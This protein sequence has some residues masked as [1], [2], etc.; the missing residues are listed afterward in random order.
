MSYQGL[1]PRFMSVRIKSFARGALEFIEQSPNNFVDILAGYTKLFSMRGIPWFLSADERLQSVAMTSGAYAKNYVLRPM[2]IGQANNVA[3]LGWTISD[4]S[5]AAVTEVDGTAVRT[6]GGN[7]T[8]TA[9]AG[10]QNAYWDI[11]CIDIPDAVDENGE[12]SVSFDYIR[13]AGAIAAGDV[14]VFLWNGTREIPMSPLYLVDSTT[15]VTFTCRCTADGAV[16]GAASIRLKI[17]SAGTPSFT[18]KATN[19]SLVPCHGVELAN[20]GAYAESNLSG[21]N[22]WFGSGGYYSLVGTTFTVLRAGRGRIQGRPVYWNGGETCTLVNDKSYIICASANRTL[23]AIDVSTLI[24]ANLKVTHENYVNLYKNYIPLFQVWKNAT[25]DSISKETHPYAYPAE[26]AVDQH[27]RAGVVFTGPGAKLTLNDALTAQIEI[28]GEDL[29]SDHGLE[30]RVPDGTGVA[31]TVTSVYQ[32]GGGVGD[33]YGSG[34]SLPAV[35]VAAGTPTNVGVGKFTIGAIYLTKDDLQTPSTASPVPQCFMVLSTAGDYNSALLAAASIGTTDVPDL[36]QFTLPQQFRTLEP[37]IIGFVLLEGDGAGNAD[38]PAYTAGGF[39]SGIRPFKA[40]AG[41]VY[42]AGAVNTANAI[43]VLVDTSNLTQ[44][45]RSTESNVQAVVD[46]LDDYGFLGDWVATT[47]TYRYG[48]IV[49]LTLAQDPAYS[50]FWRCISDHTAAGAFV[51]DLVA[52][53]WEKI[54]LIGVEV[55]EIIAASGTLNVDFSASLSHVR[56]EYSCRKAASLESEAG[57]V[58]LVTDGTN[59]AIAQTV[60]A[61]GATSLSLTASLSG[62]QIRLTATNGDGAKALTFRYRWTGWA[63]A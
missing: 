25:A 41:T 48:N 62:G 31:L 22:E 57:T 8:M 3:P 29:M 51:T 1:D 58:I 36:T 26:V 12:F 40:T 39:V 32:N 43:N 10:V 42:S 27:I 53:K 4:V 19:F 59:V 37:A 21:L 46:R 30:S 15:A 55:S 2:P 9:T 33:V 16:S 17:L 13:T 45:L 34:T 11:P 44:Q 60:A 52:G 61:T 24:G 56:V 28:Q 49:R 63:I 23:T 47:A 50:G 5:L 35:R 18:L 20:T 54:S 14:G 38:I 7:F 6:S